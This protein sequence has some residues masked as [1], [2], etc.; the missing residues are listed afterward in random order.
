MVGISIGFTMVLFAISII[1]IVAAGVKSL[2]QGK[3]DGKRIVLV[4]IPV[5]VFGLSLAFFNGDFPKAGVFTAILLFVVMI[6]TIGITGLRGT[7]K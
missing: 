3:I 5:L 1:A 4:L 7:F 2:I 6:L